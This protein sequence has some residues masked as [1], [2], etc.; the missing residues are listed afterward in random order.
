MSVIDRPKAI[1]YCDGINA[2]LSKLSPVSGNMTRHIKYIICSGWWCSNESSNNYRKLAYGSDKIRDR[3]FHKIWYDLICK[4]TNP[5]KIFIVDSASPI[6]PEL[7]LKDTRLQ[8][9]SLTHNPGHATN[10][11]GLLCGWTKAVIL[12]LEYASLCATDYFVYIE[13]DT[14][15]KGRGI[16]EHCIQHMH[17]PYMFGSGSSTPQP[18]QQSFFI[19]RND[20][21]DKFLRRIKQIPIRDN[22]FSPE[23]KF[24]VAASRLPLPIGILACRFATLRK[25]MQLWND[26]DFLPIGYGRKRPI[27]FQDEYFYAQHMSDKEL[28]LFEKHSDSLCN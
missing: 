7:N 28:V 15:I 10:H 5:E 6:K 25:F 14:L 23:L 19:I 22:Q 2:T 1:L 3:T 24:Y 27:N 16:I 21:I 13:Q 4:N 17:K 8:L 18:L 26:F 20:G 11:T 12:G 9:V